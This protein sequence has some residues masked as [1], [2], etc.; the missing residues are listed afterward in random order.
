MDGGEKLPRMRSER[1][2]EGA[3]ELVGPRLRRRRPSS[4]HAPLRRGV[5]RSAMAQAR[6]CP[7][8]SDVHGVSHRAPRSPTGLSLHSKGQDRRWLRAARS[9]ALELG[10]PLCG[11]R[12]RKRLRQ[13]TA[14]RRPA[15]NWGWQP[16]H[17]RASAPAGMLRPRPRRADAVLHDAGR[18]RIHR[19]GAAGGSKMASERQT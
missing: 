3:A 9:L 5:R 7:S 10:A 19:Y 6:T 16:K 14:G 18:D 12:R 13:G 4:A 2:V 17:R 11:G 15:Q 1:I 8:S